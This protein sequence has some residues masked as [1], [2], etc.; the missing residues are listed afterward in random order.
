[1]TLRSFC[2][3]EVASRNELFE[4][5]HWNHDPSPHPRDTQP[6]RF[7]KRSNRRL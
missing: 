1:M 3:Y 2:F 4:R 5:V 6:T 7:R